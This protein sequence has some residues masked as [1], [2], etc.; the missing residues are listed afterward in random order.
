[1]KTRITFGFALATAATLAAGGHLASATLCNVNLTNTGT[2]TA[3]DV[4]V[5]LPGIQTINPLT[6]L[7]YGDSAPGHDDVFS[8]A[9][10]STVSGNTVIDFTNPT[11]PYASGAS[12][13]QGHVGW[14]PSSGGCG[15]ADFYWTDVNGNRIP[16]SHLPIV[17]THWGTA[18]NVTF[19]NTSAFAVTLASVT[20]GVV[21]SVPLPDLSRFNTELT[22]SLKPLGDDV[23][24]PAGGFV[25]FPFPTTTCAKKPCSNVAV[26]HLSSPNADGVV[27]FYVE[28]P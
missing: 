10:I 16:G 8:N 5:V 13:I 21:T 17:E 2:V 24:V 20:G 12:V 26:F 1:M 19:V 15:L 11:T 18:G 27:D 7:Y 14:T 22:R 28:E 25:T 23:T 3:Y 9:V 6:G 4:A